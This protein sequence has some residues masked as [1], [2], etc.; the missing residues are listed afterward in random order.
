MYYGIRLANSIHICISQ[1]TIKSLKCQGWSGGTW[2]Y[3]GFKTWELR[4]G[5]L[6]IR[7][8]FFA[9]GFPR[10]SKFKDVNIVNKQYGDQKM[11]TKKGDKNMK[12]T[13]FSSAFFHNFFK[14]TQFIP[15]YFLASYNHIFFSSE[16]KIHLTRCTNISSTNHF[17]HFSCA[18]DYATEKC[19]QVSRMRVEHQ[20]C[21]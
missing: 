6:E 16:G 1:R 9:P 5:S 11:K 21:N 19:T 20:F 3:K 14:K 12:H 8:T 10:N 15:L 7:K 4:S 13:Y 17:P 18:I 2:A